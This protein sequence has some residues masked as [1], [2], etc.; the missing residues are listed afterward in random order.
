MFRNVFFGI[1]AVDDH[2]LLV[3]RNLVSESAETQRAV[4]LGPAGGYSAAER[5]GAIELVG[6]RFYVGTPGG[7]QAYE[8]DPVRPPTRVVSLQTPAPVISVVV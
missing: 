5:R 6:S 4:D 7:L 8:L 3:R 2:L 1:T